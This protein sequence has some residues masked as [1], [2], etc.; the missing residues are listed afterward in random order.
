MEITPTTSLKKEKTQIENSF[1][2]THRNHYSVSGLC[3]GMPGMYSFKES[4]RIS[5]KMLE[6]CPF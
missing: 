4:K 1:D 3:F 5:G 6:F 2:S